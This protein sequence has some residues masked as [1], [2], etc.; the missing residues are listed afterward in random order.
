MA[1]KKQSPISRESSAVLVC[2]FLV[3]EELDVVT[4]ESVIMALPP[5][6]ERLKLSQIQPLWVALERLLREGKVLTIGISDLD[7]DLL[8]ELHNWAQVRAVK[9]FFL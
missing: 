7:T 4:L 9:Q 1:F 3:L 8:I 6:D 2:F 5:N